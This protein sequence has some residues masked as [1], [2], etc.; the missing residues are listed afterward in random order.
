MSDLFFLDSIRL[1]HVHLGRVRATVSHWDC[2]SLCKVMPFSLYQF[3]A[4]IRPTAFNVLVVFCVCVVYSSIIYIV[5]TVIRTKTRGD[6]FDCDQFL[7]IK[8]AFKV[9]LVLWSQ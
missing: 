3:G 8:L 5:L 2:V 1:N 9:V 7:I 4:T 6:S